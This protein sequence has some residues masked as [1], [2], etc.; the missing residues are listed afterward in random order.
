MRLCQ[1]AVCM[2]VSV[3][4]CMSVDCVC[5]WDG[6]VSAFLHLFHVP[7]GRCDCVIM[8]QYAMVR[9]SGVLGMSVMVF[10]LCNVLECLGGG[11]V[12]PW[13]CVCVTLGLYVC[14]DDVTCHQ[15]GL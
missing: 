2:T 9:S 1:N 13:D 7:W 15:E 5:Q 10:V 3:N 6:V 8:C 14:Q 11:G 4:Y 12:C